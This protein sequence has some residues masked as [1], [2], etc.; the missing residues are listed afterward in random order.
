MPQTLSS[1][2]DMISQLIATP[3]VSCAHADLDMS[4]RNVIDLLAGWTESLGF[5][6]E[7]QTINQDKFNLIATSGEGSD[8]LVLSGHTDTVP[9]D[10]ALW[11][12]NP[13]EMSEKSDRL[14]G[15]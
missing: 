11:Q 10:E 3:S 8:G 6:T 4:N 12:T 13:F 1:T 14:Y 9:C 2:K 5:R 7:I 15:L